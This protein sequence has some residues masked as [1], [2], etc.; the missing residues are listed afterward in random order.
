MTTFAFCCSNPFFTAELM[1]IWGEDGEHAVRSALFYPVLGTV[2]FYPTTG[3]VHK[4]GTYAISL[5][6]SEEDHLCQNEIL[7][8]C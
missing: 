2:N 1:T 3:T 8:E 7:V 5:I 6:N 4:R